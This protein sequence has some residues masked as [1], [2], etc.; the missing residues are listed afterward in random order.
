MEDRSSLYEVQRH[1]G[2][3]GCGSAAL[4]K[5][6]DTGKLFHGKIFENDSFDGRSGAETAR[7][8]ESLRDIQNLVS[9]ADSFQIKTDFG[10][11]AL[12]L[13]TEYCEGGDL[14]SFIKSKGGKP[15]LF[16]QYMKFFADLIDALNEFD[17]RNLLHRDIKPD[18][19]LISIDA[20]KT[21]TL[22]L[23]EFEIATEDHD[24]LTDGIGT[25]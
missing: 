1:L 4:F 12:V 17:K 2:R 22:K 25:P 5:R 24:C 14:R 6:K 16:P 8:Y 18:N 11:R 10:D 20:E 21:M 9:Y 23:G 3:S 19:C 15:D 13:L 7:L